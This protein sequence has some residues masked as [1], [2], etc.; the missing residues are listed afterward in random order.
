LRSTAEAPWRMPPGVPWHRAH[1]E[2]SAPLAPGRPAKVSFELMPTSWIFKAGH[3]IQVTVTG[4]DYRE[5]ARDQ[6]ALARTIRIHT[7]RASPS[8]VTLPLVRAR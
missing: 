6:G 3:R 2:D 1:Q 7:D 4:S 5:R 8:S